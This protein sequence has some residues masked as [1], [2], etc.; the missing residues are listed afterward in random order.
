MPEVPEILCF[1]CTQAV[2]DPPRL[3]C[4]ADGEVCPACRDRVLA[5]L[6]PAL[7]GYGRADAP[8]E[9]ERE[10]TDEGARDETRG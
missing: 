8:P 2:G 5:A 9:G 1:H 4:L 10:S 3:N 6:P 7:P